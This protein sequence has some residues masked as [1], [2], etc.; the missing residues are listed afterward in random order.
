MKYA[1]LPITSRE[2]KLMLNV[3]HFKEQEQ[4]VREFWELVKFLASRQGAKITEPDDETGWYK[5]E[6]RKTYYLDTEALELQRNGFIVRV[7]EEEK[8]QK[9]KYKLTLKY[10]SGDRYSSAS[11]NLAI[12]QIEALNSAKREE[13]FEEDIIPPFTS[14]F[15]HSISL[16]YKKEISFQTIDN[17]KTI[18][19]GLQEL[20]IPN[21]QELKIVNNFIANEVAFKLNH[22]IAFTQET[23]DFQ[24]KPCLSFWYLLGIQPELPLVG[25]F[26]FDY[27]LDQEQFELIAKD[28][29]QLERFPYQVIKGANQLFTAIQKQVNWLNLNSTTKTSYAYE[30]FATPN[31]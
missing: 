25:E 16:K 18:F 10:R 5:L 6:K 3:T 9:R 29:N 17:L 7:R 20:N 31:L 11:K 30:G 27:D 2:Y 28:K 4:G 22:R 15:S 21:N 8:E 23:K 19:T 12:A 24:L 26:S 13:K 1:N 14:K